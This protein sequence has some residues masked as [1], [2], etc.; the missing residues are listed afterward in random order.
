MW[1]TSLTNPQC[2]YIPIYRIYKPSLLPL[3]GDKEEPEE[4]LKIE[5]NLTNLELG[6]NLTPRH[7]PNQH[8]TTCSAGLKR[9][10][11]VQGPL[12]PNSWLNLNKGVKNGC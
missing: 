4:S 10:H 7:A 3:T 11:R 9:K 6:G 12:L 1:H 8:V 2:G 5:L